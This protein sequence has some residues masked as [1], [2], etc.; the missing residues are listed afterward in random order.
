MREASWQAPHK[1][2][3]SQSPWQGPDHT[4]Y[5]PD[6]SKMISLTQETVSNPGL[7]YRNKNLPGSQEKWREGES[8]SVKKAL[9]TQGKG[10]EF[11]SRE[12][13]CGSTP[14]VAMIKHSNKSNRRKR[15]LSQLNSRLQSITVGKSKLKRQTA[16]HSTSS[17]EGK[18]ENV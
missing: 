11:G 9:A 8:S 10:S 18:E 14:P 7:T 12:P 3:S 6:A 4:D 16:S 2:Q 15:G 13:A 1:V 17:Q 5:S